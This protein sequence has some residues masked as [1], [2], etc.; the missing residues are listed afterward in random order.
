MFWATS[1]VSSS[2]NTTTQQHSQEIQYQDLKTRTENTLLTLKT[3]VLHL[4]AKVQDLTNF[5]QSLLQL[6]GGISN[7]PVVVASHIIT[8][9]HDTKVTVSYGKTFH[10][11]PSITTTARDTITGINVQCTLISTAHKECEVFLSCDHPF[12]NPIE[13]VCVLIETNA[14]L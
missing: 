7:P 1:S 11:L 6:A 12:T 4:K 5:I 14:S 9:G 13:I 3:T 10:R 8:P 2:Q